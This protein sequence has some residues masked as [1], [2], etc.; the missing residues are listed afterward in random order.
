MVAQEHCFQGYYKNPKATEDAFR[1]GWY[2][3]GDAGYLDEKGDLIFI[4]RL[5]DLKVLGNGNRYSPQYIESCL[6]FSPYIREAIVVE[7]V[8]KSL[9]GL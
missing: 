7:D 5:K 9:M 6:K 2:H 8:G 3:T 4:D 1:D